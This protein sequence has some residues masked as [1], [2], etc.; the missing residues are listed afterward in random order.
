MKDQAQIVIIGGGI[1]RSASCLSPCENGAEG[2]CPAGKGRDRQRR[3]VACRGVGD[4]V[5]HVADHAASSACTASSCTA[6]WACSTTSAVCASPR[7]RSSSRIWSGASAARRRLGWS[8]KSSVPMKRS[9]TCRRSRRRIFTARSI[10][11]ATDISIH[12]LTT[13]SMA[14]FAKELGVTVYTNTRVTGIELSAKGEVT[15]VVTDKGIHQNRIGRQRRGPVG[16]AHRRDGGSPF[17]DH[18]G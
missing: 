9:S 18:A 15:A 1:V 10:C 4:A 11:R 3:V 17:P 14:K 12:T 13:T 7:R 5:R 6:N 16:A 2:Y 8:A